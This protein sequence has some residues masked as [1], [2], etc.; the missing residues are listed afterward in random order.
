MGHKREKLLK[1]LAL[2]A[3][4]LLLFAGARALADAGG[5]AGDGDYGSWD[6]GSSWDS[7]SSWDSGSSWYGSSSDSSSGDGELDG[8]VTIV[9]GGAIVVI[10]IWIDLSERKKKRSA[11]KKPKNL[12]PVEDL[13]D[14]DPDFDE[15]ALCEQIS[16]LYVRMQNAW[17]AKDFSV[18]RPFFTDGLY[19]QFDRQLQQIAAAGKTNHIDDI[20]VLDVSLLGWKEKDEK[21]WLTA[22]V[23]TRITIYSTDDQT[24]KI[25][26]GSKKEVKL[27]EYEW[28]LVRASDQKTFGE[29]E[30][31][32][33]H[34]PNCGATLSINHSAECPY[35]GS[36]VTCNEYG[37]TIAQI[38]GVAQKTVK[39]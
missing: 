13:L 7:D 16:N 27:M 32:S 29:E 19:Q 17:T 3:A 12:R 39:K 37:W 24:G 23:K 30:V 22:R 15:A 9:T 8:W 36:V 2:L 1:W 21:Q 38:R 33:V 28:T 25:V 34:C 4:A 35:C 10:A 26:S 5:F 6:S 18:M 14:T 31:R 20:G 11:G